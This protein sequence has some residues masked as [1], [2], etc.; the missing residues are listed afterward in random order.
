MIINFITGRNVAFKFYLAII[1]HETLN[2]NVM[3]VTVSRENQLK[4]VQ[5]H[6]QRQLEQANKI[7][8]DKLPFIDTSEI[9]Y[10]TIS[11]MSWNLSKNLTKWLMHWW[12]SGIE[13][14]DLNGL[15]LPTHDRR[16][17]LQAR[18]LV[19][20]AT[21]HMT[22]LV[23]AL[24]NFYTYSEQRSKIYPADGTHEAYSPVNVQVMRKTSLLL[25]MIFSNWWGTYA[26]Q[27]LQ[28]LPVLWFRS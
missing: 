1:T 12:F 26:V 6:L 18:E 2:D 28:I 9:I 13:N 22:E 21:N 10:F 17:Q 4:T 16:H 3:F 20:Q 8:T 25:R 27:F 23:Q 24:S 15:N 19:S 14:R 7:I 5:C 11:D